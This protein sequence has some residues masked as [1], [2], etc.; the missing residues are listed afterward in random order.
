MTCLE[1]GGKMTSSRETVKYD[2]SGLSGITLRNV[3]VR[4]CA[5]CGRYEVVIPK[6]EQLHQL[7]AAI[8]IRKTDALAAEEIR[9]LRKYLGWSGVDFAAHMGATAETVSRWENGKLAMSAQADRLLRAM[10]ALGEP[11]SDYTLDAL[12]EIVPK[13]TTKPLRVGLRSAPSGW[14][15]ES[16]A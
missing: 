16:A 4:R 13:R 7:I 1:C 11:Q 5:R 15:K 9:F 6:I 2:A 14:R 12:K 8:V 3:E 10:V